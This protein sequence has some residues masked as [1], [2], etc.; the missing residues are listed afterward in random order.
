MPFLEKDYF[1]NLYHEQRPKKG[2]VEIPETF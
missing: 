1:K 2:S